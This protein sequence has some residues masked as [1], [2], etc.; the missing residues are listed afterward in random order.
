M[1][2]RS[3]HAGVNACLQNVVPRL[4]DGVPLC[5]DRKHVLESARFTTREVRVQT[6][7]FFLGRHTAQHPIEELLRM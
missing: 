6:E 2:E 3:H 1:P 5:I 7:H 4:T